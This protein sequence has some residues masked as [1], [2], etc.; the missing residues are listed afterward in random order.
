VNITE[1][2]IRHH[3]G[4]AM[5]CLATVV[6][7]VVSYVSMPREDFP[8]VEFPFVI[9]STFQDGANPVDVEQGITIPLETE[10]DGVEGLKEMRSASLDSLSMVSLEFH[11]DVDTE[12]ALRRVR[13]AVDQAKPDISPEAEEPVVKEFSVSSFPVR[14]YHL[15]GTG[16]VS[17][18]ELNELAENLEDEIKLIPGVLDVDTIGARERE[19]V[20]EVDP[21]R[22]HFYRLSLAQVQGI[23][24]GTNRNVSAGNIDSATGRI[25]VRVPG[26]FRTPGEI[27]A[28]VIGASAEGT[29]IYMRDVAVVYPSFEDETSRARLYDFSA[30]GADGRVAPLPSVSLHITKR[31]GTNV[32]G[33]C[34]RLD[35]VLA[36]QALSDSVRIVKGLDRSKDVETMVSD[37]ENGIGTALVLVLLVIFVGM[38]LMNSLLVAAAIPF[39]MLMA[40]VV[41][42]ATGE[43]LNMM[44]LFSLIL[45]LGML[46][47]NAIVIVENIYRHFS[48]G[49]SRLEAALLGTREV[50]WPVITSTMTTVAAFLPLLFWP[51]IMG[52]FMSYLPR[53]VINVMLCSLFTALVITPTVAAYTMRLKPG[54]G[55]TIDPE[56]HRPH[57]WLVRKYQ[58]L[59]E[60]MVDR[61]NW[62]LATAAAVLLFALTLFGAFNAGVELF[63]PVDPKTVTCS[64]KPPDGISLADSDRLCRELEQ[65]LFGGGPGSPFPEPVQNL[66]YA[67]VSVGLQGANGANTLS[68]QNTGP[69]TIEVEFRDTDK[70]TELTTATLQEMRQRLEGLDRLGNSVTHPLYG[71][72]FDVLR[73]QDGPPTGAPVSVDILGD[74]LG[75]MTRVIA[76]MKQIINRTPG[77]VKATDDAVTAQPTLEWHV[78]RDRAGMLGLDQATI[79]SIVQI[80]VGGLET[81]KFG[82]GEDEQ[83]I[84][85]RAPEAYRLDTNRLRNLT[86][87]LPNSRAVPLSSVAAPEL[88]PGPI[89]IKH[90][91][92]RRVLN[93]SAE[94]QPGLRR[95]AD[96]RKVFQ[97]QVR[98]YPFPPDITYRFGG[99]AEEEESA[100]SFLGKA[101]LVALFLILIIIV[102]QFNT[103]AAP[104]IIMSSVILSLVGVM[105]GLVA[106]RSP[107]GIVM[108]GIGV[109]SLAGVVVNNAIVLL[110]AVVQHE[111]RGLRTR[112][113]VISAAMIRFRPVLLTAITTVLGLLPM[114][115]KLN[116][117]FRSMSWQRNTESSQWWQSMSLSV[118]FGLTVATV[119][120]LGVVPSMYMK[121]AQ[122][123]ARWQ[124]W[125]NPA[126]SPAAEA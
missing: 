9:V 84:M 116:W 112:E 83:D 80:A 51:G 4:V 59:L 85:I 111:R 89:T 73:P 12:T 93:A 109:I 102:L 57:Y 88:V 74:D 75:A 45:A 48:M 55:S 25:A 8:D 105:V 99:A 118:I 2:A 91:D 24:R 50:T 61:P 124:R 71:A 108:T 72:D 14:I 90:I 77:T 125:R 38:G 58:P 40:T 54:A 3:V 95:D 10:L 43:T 113:A 104:A 47:D 11:P 123:R 69:V 28:L 34:R 18:S 76:D 107:F 70:R 23:L 30:A 96:I 110:D 67:S 106:M 22:L 87:P 63:P 41:L 66:K 21:E 79:A 5:L 39:S 27:Y 6:I 42:Q 122:L 101:F 52:Q 64:I 126:P 120:T 1:F 20:I 82:H 15:V 100:K 119:L 121:Y 60:F 17:I 68:E 44:V 31:T 94:I 103:L 78:A 33:L 114:A 86:I 92:T 36:R 53:T 97:E 37:L 46:V 115:L 56:T 26:E 29:P 98:D 19:I 16:N 65:R 32:L 62:T 13:D 7:G 35:E 49:R 81:G 117:D